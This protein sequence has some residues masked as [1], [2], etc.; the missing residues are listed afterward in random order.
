MEVRAMGKK[1][2]G[3]RISKSHDNFDRA[4]WAL[5]ICQWLKFVWDVIFG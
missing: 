5:L 3:K 4:K 1:T 2:N